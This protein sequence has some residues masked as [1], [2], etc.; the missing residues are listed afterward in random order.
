MADEPRA[1]LDT[2]VAEFYNALAAKAGAPRDWIINHILR[3]AGPNI[4]VV[5]TLEMKQA[6]T[7]RGDKTII[8]KPRSEKKWSAKI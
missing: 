8:V 6:A 4:T 5:L 3:T 7:E 2:D 1:R